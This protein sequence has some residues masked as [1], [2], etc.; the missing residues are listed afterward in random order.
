MSDSRL[1]PDL[2][3]I[4]THTRDVWGDLRGARLFLTGGTGFFGCWLLGSFVYAQ[5]RLQ[6]SATIT[7]LTRDPEAF[8]LKAPHLA[9]HPAVTLLQGDVRSFAFP[10][11]TFSHVIHAA[12]EA[13]VTLDREQPEMM[14]ETITGG[15]QRV[16]AFLEKCEAQK[17]L[18]IS[19]GAVYGRQPALVTHMSEDEHAVAAP[20]AEYSAYAAGKR[21]AERLWQQSSHR[22]GAIAR[23]FAFVGPHLP[24]DAHFAV[25]NFIRD[26][27]QGGPICVNG[28]GTPMRSYLYA[29]DLA[30][31]LW[32]IL[33]QGAAGRPYNVGSEEDCSIA[34]IAN[35]AAACF[36]PAPEVT[37]AQTPVPGHPVQQYV[38][39]TLRAR[40]ELGLVQRIA[41]SEAI[42]KTAAWYATE[43]LPPQV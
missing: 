37:I 23:C 30:I 18:L 38:P 27:L 12:T 22:A 24:L 17:S 31:W 20:L 43:P 34:E 7:L 33:L 21:E 39:S 32:I 6:L 10:S 19:S 4:L 8:K 28:D 40:T 5:D 14:Y 15:T 2:E 9:S 36:H 16:L 1:L 26:G 41:L 35:I 42:R 3:H 11:G 13:S 29:A 25:G